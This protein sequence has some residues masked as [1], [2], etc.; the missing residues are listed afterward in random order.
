MSE[1]FVVVVADEISAS[2]LEPLTGDPRFEVL[3]ANGWDNERLYE[4]MA[5]AHGLIVRSATKVT[6]ELLEVSPNL[7]VV[8]RAGVGV[9]NIDV[10]VATEH[11]IPVINAPEG[12][13][14]SAAELVM[15]LM[16]AVA[17]K[18]SSADNSVRSGEW[19]RSRFAGMELRGKTLSL[20]GAG[21]IGAEVA[22]RAQAFGMRTI[23]NDPYLTE[24]R[25]NE[26]EVERV[27]LAGALAQGDVVSLH[28]PL[29][30][31]TEGMI[32]RKELQSM[33][34][35]AI[36]INAARGGVVDED[37]LVAALE[38][39]EIAGAAPSTSTTR[40]PCLR[41]VPCGVPPTWFS[42]PTSVPPR[43]RPR[44]WS[45]P[46]SPKA[47][48]RRSSRGI[49]P[50]PSMRR[51]SG[52]L[53]SRCSSPFSISPGRSGGWP[54]CWD[55]EGCVVSTSVWPQRRTRFSIRYPPP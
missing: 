30:P 14:V 47:C 38:A 1:K 43:W 42:R 36:L 41:T 34:P 10:E 19:A 49:F 53:S 44:S 54:A 35:T 24:E 40:S 26:L 18:V 39:G 4:A 5:M 51:P 37:A 9:D 8:G 13:T 11:G 28:V 23:A 46:R 2:G 22:H 55:G 32:G 20:V 6:R 16:L 50:G 12:N 29:T 21:R 25:A 33:K 52:E 7:R 27:E 45:P 3:M 15:A 31:I 48:A 17:R